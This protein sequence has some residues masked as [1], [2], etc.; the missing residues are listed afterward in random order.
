[1][2][3]LRKHDLKLNTNKCLFC[4]T[5]NKLLGFIISQHKMEIDPY[6]SK[7][8]KRCQCQNS[9]EVRDFSRSLHCLIDNHLQAFVQTT[10]KECTDGLR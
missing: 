8:V 9:E 2:K 1:M 3:L 6:K 5:S 10:Q 4:A 7:P